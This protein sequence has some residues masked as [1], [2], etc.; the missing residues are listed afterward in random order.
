MMRKKFSRTASSLLLSVVTALSV[1]SC[2][3]VNSNNINVEKQSLSEVKTGKL[4]LN[5]S[6]LKNSKFSTKG[7]FTDPLITTVRVEVEGYN[8]TK[9]T[10]SFDWSPSSVASSIS[11]NVPAGKNRVVS[12]TGLDDSNN[13]I[14]KLM[15]LTDISM[16]SPNVL[17]L[18]YGETPAARVV[19]MILNGTRKEIADKIDAN[20]L[21][22]LINNITGYSDVDNSYDR[23][24]NFVDIN[25]IAQNVMAND[26]EIDPDITTGLTNP[27]VGD[28]KVIV[29]DERGNNILSGVKLSLNDISTHSFTTNGAT[30]NIDADAGY[31]QLTAK[32]FVNAQGSLTIPLNEEEERNIILSGGNRLYAKA[33]VTVKDSSEQ[34]ITLNLK[35]LAVDRIELYKDDVKVDKTIKLELGRPEDFDAR[36]IFEDE[37]YEKDEVIWEVN[38]EDI[39]YVT[40]SGSISGLKDGSTTLKLI[41]IVDRDIDESYTLDVQENILTP[42]IDTFTPSTGSAGDIVTISGKNFN[43]LVPSEN[44]VRFNGVKA[45]VLSASTESLRVRLPAGPT[46]GYISVV[47]SNGSTTS[48]LKFAGSVT[49]DL[50]MVRV[51]GGSFLMGSPSGTGG[52]SENP[53]ITV[54]V[55]TFLVDKYEVTNKEYKEFIKADAYNN[56]EFWTA[57]GWNWKVKNNITQP[58]YWNDS[59]VNQDNQPVVGIS[60]YE[61]SAYAKWAGKRLATEAEWEY[62]ARGASGNSYPWGNDASD[63]STRVNG[64]FGSEGGTD[65][66]K[67][68][69]PVGRF[70]GGATPNTGIYTGTYTNTTCAS[71]ITNP[72]TGNR[73]YDLSGNVSEWVSDWYQFEYL[74]RDSNFTNPAGPISG[75]FKAAKGGSWSNGATELR[76]PYREHYFNPESRSKTV[77]FRCAKNIGT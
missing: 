2:S 55:S 20:D 44:I 11:L 50:N 54:N 5:L 19:S 65:G 4:T 17:S 45:D 74:G 53:Q 77:G 14:A 8:M 49:A 41:S 38:N 24:P 33:M 47:T 13:I 68:V 58:A 51:A 26:G 32:A 73:I 25:A 3:Q 61:A 48:T 37:T 27:V 75:S 9:Q 23:N 71:D 64:F 39:A 43:D 12:I 56:S 69:A 59:T 76:A 7:I 30:T 21:K 18:N 62:A 15:G 66:F 70:C 28:L 52:P 67:F 16:D 29:K 60:W 10:M 34:E 63:I 31:W 57:S 40:P 42:Y 22:E 46:S 6:V 1:A 36:V 72:D 35:P